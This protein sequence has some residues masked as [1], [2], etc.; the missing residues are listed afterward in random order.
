MH[1]RIDGAVGAADAHAHAVR[2]PLGGEALRLAVALDRLDLEA[3]LD[4]GAVGA[5][6]GGRK[7]AQDAALDLAALGPD[8]DRLGDLEIAVA[9]HL[10]RR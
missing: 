9:L 1:A 6:V 4:A 10:R 5:A 2:H 8:R 7:I 3:D